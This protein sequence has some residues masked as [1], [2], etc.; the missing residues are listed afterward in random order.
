MSPLQDIS[1]KFTMDH[2]C[3]KI[4]EIQDRTEALHQINPVMFEKTC[5]APLAKYVDD[6]LTVPEI[7]RR[8][9][10]W[11]TKEAALIWTVEA[12]NAD[13][14]RDPEEIRLPQLHPGLPWEEQ[15]QDHASLGHLHVGGFPTRKWDLLEEILE[16]KTKLPEKTGVIKIV[17]LYKFYRKSMANRTPL[18]SRAACPEGDRIQTVVNEFIR[19][20]KNTSRNLPRHTLEA[21]LAEYSCDLK[22][23]GFSPNWVK[24]CLE[25]ATTGYASMVQ[26]EVNGA[27][28]VNRPEHS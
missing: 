11:S 1:F 27:N 10:R 28:P 13:K 24:K 7:M 16:H 2:W 22:R 21:T 20:M 19:R 26:N 9:V 5:A 6:I 15:G 12:H 17:I 25:A 23:G 18:H 4:Q 8:G 14:D 3:K